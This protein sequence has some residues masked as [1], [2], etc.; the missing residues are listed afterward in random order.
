MA[1]DSNGADPAVLSSS[2]SREDWAD[3]DWSKVTHEEYVTW[4][5]NEVQGAWPYLHYLWPSADYRN[6]EAWVTDGSSVWVVRPGLSVSKRPF[7]QFADRI[8]YEDRF[9]A[10]GQV[11]GADRETWWVAVPSNYFESHY[12]ERE[13]RGLPGSTYIFALLTHEI[14]H[15]TPQSNW[16]VSGAD[17]ERSEFYPVDIEARRLRGNLMYTLR[18]AILHTEQRSQYLDRAAAW[19]AQWKRHAPYEVETRTYTDIKEGT[20]QYLDEAASVRAYVGPHASRQ[21]IDNA[22]RSLIENDYSMGAGRDADADIESYQIGALA[23]I[24]LEQG[25][26]VDWK[27]KAMRGVTP[28]DT[29]L[30]SR[31]QVPSNSALEVEKLLETSVVPKA[32]LAR[33][34]IEPLMHQL[35]VPGTKYLAFSALPDL[36]SYSSGGLFRVKDL[37][38]VQFG[39]DQVAEYRFGAA[40]IALHHATVAG[41]SLAKPCR[42]PNIVFS[43]VVLLPDEVRVEN[44]LIHYADD[45]LDLVGVPVSNQM[46]DKKGRV[47]LCGPNVLN[48]PS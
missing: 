31:Q 36:S 32:E 28:A 39:I 1:T 33:R 25:G 24:L 23:G 11:G 16:E 6:I 26:V 19:H 7:D 27:E 34:A 42:M 9:S 10:F 40:R 43:S 14:F 30:I 38:G 37:P 12:T 13:Y 5:N 2:P 47:I 17:A 46:V 44:G 45:T 20:A 41:G 22:Y 15:V 3:M 4:F 8:P 29:L 48:P 21:Q 18:Q 35:E